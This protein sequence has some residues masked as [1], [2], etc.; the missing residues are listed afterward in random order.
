MK[1][2]LYL[3]VVFIALGLNAQNNTS[4]FSD[5]VTFVGK[6][7]TSI[8]KT[9]SYKEAAPVASRVLVSISVNVKKE[10]LQVRSTHFVQEVS[11]SN[12]HGKKLIQRAN[13]NS[14][15]LSQ[16]PRGVYILNVKAANSNFSK[17]IIL[18]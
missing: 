2:K 10:I 4:D 18:Q 3:L 7:Y 16:L 13:T 11:I 9:K 14:I 17:K 8:N 15:S 5:N 6:D 12:L 1:E